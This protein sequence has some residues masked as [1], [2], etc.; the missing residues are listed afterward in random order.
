MTGNNP[1]TMFGHVAI[2]EAS[3]QLRAIGKRCRCLADTAEPREQ[4]L[5]W[6]ASEATEVLLDLTGNGVAYVP[7]YLQHLEDTL[8]LLDA[9][10]GSDRAGDLEDLSIRGKA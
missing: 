5:L 3:Q 1:D 10:L 2:L 9:V 7:W 4:A 8:V 6:V